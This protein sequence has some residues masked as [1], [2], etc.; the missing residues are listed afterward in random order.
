MTAPTTAAAVR[1]PT[2]IIAGVVALVG[3]SAGSV[4]ALAVLG[5]ELSAEAKLVIIGQLMTSLGTI[6]PAMFALF[7]VNEVHHD[8]QNGLIPAKVQEGITE[9]AA[10]PDQPAVTINGENTYPHE[11]GDVTV[12]GPETFTNTDRHGGTTI[13]HKGENYY[14]R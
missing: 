5:E 8:L 10:D 11:S 4:I 9:M 12:L 1:S 7:R 2:T 13:S 14:P 3:L 6:V